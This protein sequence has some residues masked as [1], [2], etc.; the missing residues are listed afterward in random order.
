MDF[1]FGSLDT[2][3]NICKESHITSGMIEH[4]TSTVPANFISSALYVVDLDRL[5]K[6]GAADILRSTYHTLSQDPNSLSNLD[7]V[8]AFILPHPI[9]VKHACIAK[10]SL[11]M[12]CQDLPNFLQ[13]QIPIFS[14]PQE[15]LWCAT[16]CSDES[17]A[18]AKTIDLVRLFSSFA[19]V[20]CVFSL[21]LSTCPLT[22]EVQQPVNENSKTRECTPGHW[23]RVEGF[24]RGSSSCG[25]NYGHAGIVWFFPHIKR[26][27]H[28][29][30]ATSCWTN[31]H[32][33]IVKD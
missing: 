19:F 10:K 3:R 6:M 27:Q 23:S 31:R 5:R 9:G 8:H 22:S 32:I 13:H 18:Q 17:K 28:I 1:D 33:V 16:W 14:L 21:S 11:L 15:W 30:R 7:Q 24:G 4:Q 26:A 12:V 2:G 29:A 20:I 25:A